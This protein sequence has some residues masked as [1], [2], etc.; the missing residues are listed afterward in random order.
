[1]LDA[2]RPRPERLQRRQQSYQIMA[3]SL[4]RY[5]PLPSYERFA[6]L[7]FLGPPTHNCHGKT[8]NLTA[9]TKYP[10]QNWKPHGKNKI[11][12]GKT[13]TSWQKQNTSWQNRNLTAKTK[14]SQR[15]LNT[16]RQ[17]QRPHGKT[18]YFTAK[19]KDLTA[20]ANTH[21]KTKA[22]L[23]LLWSIWFC[24]EVFGFAV[25]YFVFAVRFLVLP[26]CFCFCREVFGFAV[27]VVSHHIHQSIC[28]Q[29]V[30]RKWNFKKHITYESSPFPIK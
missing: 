27:T 12:H 14:T 21:G 5:F 28:Y 3:I 8:K 20:K 18:K 17:N 13:K 29:I 24:R 11:P 25:R 16:S 30:E 26:W 19:T 15:K 1:M 9:K 6:Y 4:L 7:I 23:F 10:Q 2:P 22:I